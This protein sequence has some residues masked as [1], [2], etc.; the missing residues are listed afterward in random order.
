VTSTKLV[1]GWLVER[2]ALEEEL[3]LGTTRVRDEMAPKRRR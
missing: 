1:R 2:A 3:R